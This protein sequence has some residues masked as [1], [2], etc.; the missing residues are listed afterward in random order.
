MLDFNQPIT[1]MLMGILG[2]LPE[3]DTARTVVH[4]LPDPLPAGSYLALY[5]DTLPLE[6]AA[7]IRMQ[8]A[9]HTYAETGAVLYWS[10]R[11]GDIASLFDGLDLVDPGFVRIPLW[12]PGD[13]AR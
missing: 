11:S 8:Q 10:R 2:H 5:D 3:L 1:L 9:Q 6:P 7:R 13:H 4:E 12:W